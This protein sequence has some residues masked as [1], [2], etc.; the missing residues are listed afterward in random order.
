MPKRSIDELESNRNQGGSR[1]DRGRPAGNF[2]GPAIAENGTSTSPASAAS[3]TP[4]RSRWRRLLRVP[5]STAALV[6]LVLLGSVVGLGGLVRQTRQGASPGAVPAVGPVAGDT[7]G[8]AES[9]ILLQGTF[10]AIPDD[11]DFSGVKRAVLQPGAVWPLGTNAEDGVGPLLY[12]V[13]AGSLSVTADAPIQVTRAGSRQPE[14]VA[15]R[16]QDVLATGDQGFT[17]SGVRSVWRNAGDAP[18]SI[19]TTMVATDGLD[20]RPQG[21]R[22]DDVFVAWP[23]ARPALPAQVVVRKLTLGVHADLRGGPAAGLMLV[24]VESGSADV[25]LGPPNPLVEP[26]GHHRLEAGEWSNVNTGQWN[27]TGGHLGN[28]PAGPDIVVAVENPGPGPLTLLVLTVAP[29]VDNA[30]PHP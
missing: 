29:I 11:A 28:Q 30:T 21:V 18:V 9:A 20:P 23:I 14:T 17:P 7:T 27:A 15:A 26:T 5:F 19:L 16:T 10:E 24:G 1:A 25:I 12:R 8:I 6:S 22:Y 2:A 4:P 13:E 3:P